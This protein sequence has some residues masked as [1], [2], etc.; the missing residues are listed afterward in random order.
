MQHLN[1]KRIEEKILMASGELDLQKKWN[2][3]KYQSEVNDYERSSN[4]VY[5]KFCNG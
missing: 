4:Y 1:V 3:G 5:G 2:N